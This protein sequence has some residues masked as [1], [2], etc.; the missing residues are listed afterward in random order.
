MREVRLL[1]EEYLTDKVNDREVIFKGI[2]NSYYY[3]G[4]EI[5]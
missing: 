4:L 5:G 1:L 3:E 2:D